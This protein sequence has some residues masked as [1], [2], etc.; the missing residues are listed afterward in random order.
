MVHELFEGM[1]VVGVAVE[2]FDPHDP[3]IAGRANDSHLAAELVFFMGLAFCDALHFRGVDA[4]E[5]V[6]GMSLAL[7]RISRTTQPR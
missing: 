5:F 7:R 4:V 6:L 1:A 2:G 3:V